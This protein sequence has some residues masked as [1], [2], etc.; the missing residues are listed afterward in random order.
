MA[1]K[2][3]E[4]VGTVTNALKATGKA[5]G[6]GLKDMGAKIGSMLPGL[7]GQVAGVSSKR[8]GRWL[9]F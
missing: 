9:G 6:A 8:L 1:A 2:E 4:F 7:I 5:L 3:I